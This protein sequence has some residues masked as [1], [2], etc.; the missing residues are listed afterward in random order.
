MRLK[1]EEE[2]YN[3]LQNHVFAVFVFIRC[4]KWIVRRDCASHST[5]YIMYY[6]MFAVKTAKYG[7]SRRYGNIGNVNQTLYLY[8]YYVHIKYTDSVCARVYLGT[9]IRSPSISILGKS[10]YLAYSRRINRLPTYIPP[11]CGGRLHHRF[12]YEG[13]SGSALHGPDNRRR[14]S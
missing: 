8:T 10:Q 14:K 4:W 9:Y 3:V 7:Q 2:L 13:L 12:V 6:I 1:I 5:R 11:S